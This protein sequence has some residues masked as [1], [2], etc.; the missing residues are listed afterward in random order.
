MPR[1]E[2]GKA[3]HKICRTKAVLALGTV[4]TGSQGSRLEQEK[5][6]GSIQT[7]QD[8]DDRGKEKIQT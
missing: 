1:C 5:P 2:V 7:D 6:Q 8:G 3:H 4:K